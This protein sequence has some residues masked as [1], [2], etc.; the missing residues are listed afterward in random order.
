VAFE[1][2]EEALRNAL[3]RVL[4]GQPEHHDRRYGFQTRL[5]ELEMDS[6]RVV[7]LIVELEEEVDALLDLRLAGQFETLGDMCRSLHAVG[8]SR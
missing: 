3:S 8:E 1:I 7:S 5:D 4:A 6:L 2:S